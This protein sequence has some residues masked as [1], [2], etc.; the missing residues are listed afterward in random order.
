MSQSAYLP[1]K[2]SRVSEIKVRGLRTRLRTWG[3][4]GA[5][6]L[7]FLH[8]HRDSAATFQFMIDRM[9]GDWRIVAPDWRGHGGS[10]WAPQ[11]YWYHDYLAD[12]DAIVDHVSPDAPVSLVGHSLGGNVG[13]VFSGLRP[14][15]VRRLVSLDGFGLRNKPAEDAPA[16]LRG[17]LD[18]WKKPLRERP[19]ATR[20]DLADRLMASNPRLPREKALYLAQDMGREVEGGF[21]WTFD[22]RHRIP[23]ATLHRVDEWA[24]CWRQIEARTLWIVAGDRDKR[25]PREEEHSLAWRVSQIRD[26]RSVVVP[27][28]GHN[29]HH[30]A[31]QA[32]A[33]IIERFLAE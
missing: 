32:A 30:D 19:Y 4:D 5:P 27:D 33:E 16:H 11:G 14:H 15:R 25:T 23:F 21:A 2:P 13:S 29:I 31:P 22:P 18:A 8:G 26:A 12:L 1:E 28:T 3:A 6:L 7:L 10:E 9:R 24:A 17:W 20:E